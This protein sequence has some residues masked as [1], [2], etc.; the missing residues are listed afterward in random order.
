MIELIWTNTVRIYQK[1][2][3]FYSRPVTLYTFTSWSIWDPIIFV[4]LDN[5][6]IPFEFELLTSV[7]SFKLP[8]KRTLLHK[9]CYMIRA[10]QNWSLCHV[11][12]ATRNNGSPDTCAADS[13]APDEP[14]YPRRMIWELQCPLIS[15]W[16]PILQFSGQCS[17]QIRLH[18]G[19]GWSGATLPA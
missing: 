16:D 6:R 17:H 4:Y 1:S 18:G 7:F 10:V 2:H 9:D 11:W 13:V 19:A 8:K 5:R 12:Q 3:L 15:Q 14:A